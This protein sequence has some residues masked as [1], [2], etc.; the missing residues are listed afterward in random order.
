MDIVVGVSSSIL[1]EAFS[2]I[3]DCA[4]HN[5]FYGKLNMRARLYCYEQAKQYSVRSMNLHEESSEYD[6][7]RYIIL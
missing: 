1:G 5:V 4:S 7:K 2:A 3:A 6:P